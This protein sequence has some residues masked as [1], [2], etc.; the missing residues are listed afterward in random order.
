MNNKLSF[1][2]CL[3]I[4]D[5]FDDP[6]YEYI[7]HILIAKLDGEERLQRA[8]PILQGYCMDL[9]IG[10]MGLENAYPIGELINGVA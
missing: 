7:N 2:T 6:Q 1:D 5:W 3:D 9:V 8:F 10:H 4:L